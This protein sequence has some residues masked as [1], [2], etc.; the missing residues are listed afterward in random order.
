MST[1]RTRIFR[2][3]WYDRARNRDSSR[4]VEH[5]ELLPRVHDQRLN[6]VQVQQ[7]I[8]PNV[9]RRYSVRTGGEVLHTARRT[10][11]NCVQLSVISSLEVVDFEGRDKCADG[12]CE[13]GSK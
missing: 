13:H 3:N 4:R 9:P 8:I 1:P 2:T 7:E 6:L 5:G 10:A 11:N 12:C